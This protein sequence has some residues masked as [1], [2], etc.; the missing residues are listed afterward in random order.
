M[1]WGG[2]TVIPS[3]GVCPMFQQE[4]HAIE[5]IEICYLVQWHLSLLIPEV[6]IGIVFD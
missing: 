4:L 3:I 6:N 2:T 1:E 5:V